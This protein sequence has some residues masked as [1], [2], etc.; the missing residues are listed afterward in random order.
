MMRKT[1]LI[2]LLA[3]FSA[4]AGPLSAAADVYVVANAGVNLSGGEV[5]DVF[6]GEKQLAGAVKLVPVDNASAH[7]EFLSKVVKL[8]AGK[9]EALW[10]K[11]SF[12][13]GLNAPAAKG[14]DAEVLAVV[15][16]TPGAVGYL[17]A[18]PPAGVKLIQK[19]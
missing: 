8:D 17:S 12:R 16:S 4:L 5:R 3:V 10:T 7:A 14:G 18:P 2:S 19:F 15:K 6:V 9:Y 13:E 11:K 1:K